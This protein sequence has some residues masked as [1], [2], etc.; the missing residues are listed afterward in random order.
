MRTII[1][2]ITIIFVLI[3]LALVLANNNV[4][5]LLVRSYTEF[6]TELEALKADIQKSA[7]LPSL[8]Q[9]SAD[10]SPLPANPSAISPVSTGKVVLP[11]PLTKTSTTVSSGTA[12][13]LTRKGII[14]DTNNERQ[15]LGAAALNENTELDASAQ[16]KANDILARQYFEHTAPD[17]KTV[18]DLVTDQGYAYIK[19]GENLA[20]G[21]FKNDADVLAAWMASPGHRANILDPEYTEIGVGVAY[22]MY[23]GSMVYVAVQHFGRPRSTCPDVSDALRLQVQNGQSSLANLSATMDRLKTQIDQGRAQGNDENSL[24]ATYN[25]DITTYNTEAAQIDAIRTQYNAQVN[26]FNLCIS[27]IK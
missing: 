11:G 19:I 14:A 7:I 24:V 23:K 26:A 21:D 13:A 3:T 10:N 5:A 8:T 18:V 4:E 12:E 1:N 9:N 2:I 6:K 25:Q 17:G 22:G 20:L 16:V 15:T 27:S